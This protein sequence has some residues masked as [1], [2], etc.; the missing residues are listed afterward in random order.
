MEEL[1]NMIKLVNELAPILSPMIAPKLVDV[2]IE[3]LVSSE[4][5]REEL[6]I[7]IEK[8]MK[9]GGSTCAIC[10]TESTE[11]DLIPFPIVDLDF[12][13]RICFISNIQVTPLLLPLFLEYIY[14]ICYGI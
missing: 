6:E 8:K 12:N 1:S 5:Q 7:I 3:K 4:E 14:I 9:E 2:N 11:H 10:K 13:S